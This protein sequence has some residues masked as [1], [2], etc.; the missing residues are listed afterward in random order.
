MEYI[1]KVSEDT[2]AF[3]KRRVEFR[4]NKLK[5]EGKPIIEW[6][7]YRKAGLRPTV[8]NEVK[9]LISIKV[10]EYDTVPKS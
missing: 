6:Q 8:S 5:E 9:R 2:V 3:Q 4:I 10:T 1:C 7:I